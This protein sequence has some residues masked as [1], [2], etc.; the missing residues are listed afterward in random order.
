MEKLLSKENVQDIL[1]LTPVQEGMLLYYINAEETEVYIEQLSL[2]LEASIDLDLFNHAWD[3][4][5][6]NNEMLR[7]V[8]KWKNIS[9]PVQII[10]K[11]YVIPVCYFDFSDNNTGKT[12]AE[13]LEE[14]K[15][16]ERHNIDLEKS[17]FRIIIC[18]IAENNFQL[19]ITYSHLICDGWG[20][21]NILKEF[22]EAYDQLCQGKKL[23]KLNKAGFKQYVYFL[24]NQDTKVQ[25]D[26]WSQYLKDLTIRTDLPAENY[27]PDSAYESFELNISNDLKNICLEFTKEYNITQATLFYFTWGILLQIYCGQDDIVF[28]TT[29]SGRNIDLNSVEEIVGLFINTVPLRITFNN[30]NIIEQLRKMADDLIQR[31]QYENASLIE[32]K[33]S[34]ELK[35]PENLFDS[36]VVV[37]NYPLSH[38]FQENP[39]FKLNHYTM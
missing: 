7:T 24:Q 34:S 13:K 2:D 38:L 10:L 14:I 21:G 5:V 16:G 30:T 19:T 29:V 27:T 25:K 33:E 6:N 9:N 12:H 36:I 1:A 17:P 37:E 20:L 22:I 35:G 8:F 11:D 18:K 39:Y 23:N 32:I 3:F 4:V 15:T 31:E 26:Y 28:G